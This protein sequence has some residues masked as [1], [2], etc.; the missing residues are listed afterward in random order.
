M[1]FKMSNPQVRHGYFNFFSLQF[2]VDL[3]NFAGFN[4]NSRPISLPISSN[5]DSNQYGSSASSHNP[6]DPTL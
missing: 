3:S 1:F 5:L 2:L 4:R 6:L